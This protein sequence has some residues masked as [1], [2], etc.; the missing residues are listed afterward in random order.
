MTFRFM[1]AQ[2]YVQVAQALA[3]TKLLWSALLPALLVI[4]LIKLRKS[5]LHELNA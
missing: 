1:S 5:N 2:E 4:L 3:Y